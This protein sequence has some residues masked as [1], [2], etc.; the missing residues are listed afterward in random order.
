MKY[1][2]STERLYS[3]SSLGN[4]TTFVQLDP[5][6]NIHG[7]W[8]SLN[9]SFYLGKLSV[10]FLLG[11]KGVAPRETVF[12]PSSQST[13]LRA[14]DLEIVKRVA[15]PFFEDIETLPTGPGKV[16]VDIDVKN[17][18]DNAAELLI[19]SDF[20]FPAVASP[21]FT[22]KP[23]AEDSAK[24]FVITYTSGSLTA[25]EVGSGN[26]VVA[27]FSEPA[28]SHAT[29]DE[30][31]ELQ[32]ALIV[33]PHES[34]SFNIALYLG[35][36]KQAD[37]LVELASPMNDESASSA[38]LEELLKT[39]EFLT[40]SG[41]INR[42][43]YWAKVNTLRVQ[44]K[45][46]SG[47]GFT[48]DPPQDIVVVR[49]LAW[50]MMGSDYFRPAFSREL[51]ELTEKYCYHPDGKLTEFI[52]ADENIPELHDYNL[53][54]NDDTPLFI[55]ALRHH[56]HLDRDPD[57]VMR[58][59]KLAVP[60]VDYIL[61]QMKDG[62]IYSTAAGTNVEGIASWRNIIDDYNLSGFVT[63]INAECCEAL[64][65]ASELAEMVG[66]SKLSERYEREAA[67]LEQNILSK[68]RDGE[69]GFFLLNIDQKGVPHRDVTGDLV[70]PV[71]FE[72]GD[73]K[74][75]LKIV[76]RL[77]SEDLWTKHGARTVAASDPTYDPE[78]GMNLMGGIW[79]NLTAWFA[80]ASKEFYSDV[81][82]EAMEKIYSISESAS[83]R[84][85]G[86]VIP[87]EFPERLHGE[88]FMSMGMGMSP[89]MPPTYLW[90]GI[91]G[92]LGLKVEKGSVK[93]EPSMPQAWSFLCV[94]DIPI[95]SEKLSV[96]IYNGI[97]YSDLEIESEL[98]SRLGVFTHICRNDGLRVFKFTDN[99]GVKFFAFSF[100]EYTGSV[101]IPVNEHSIDFNLSLGKD[102]MQEIN[103]DQ[104]D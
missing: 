36:E 64:R 82:A 100:D 32:F 42:G 96:V 1:V 11:G 35:R 45:F 58:A 27:R 59:F 55:L 89:W 26:N 3:G 83:P 19:K 94:F 39:S 66:A 2:Y 30:T 75:R 24:K 73:R 4:L 23:P 88:T 52:H 5:E 76:N 29:D 21:L 79:P 97:L 62:L 31:A 46:R 74:V 101:T 16:F 99:I 48:N 54:I 70:F 51:V 22:K 81:V 7:V 103:V 37:S 67:R 20:I 84:D 102:E 47:F 71:L 65:A 17:D 38:K 91:E 25:L 34:R 41:T 61:S 60:A 40:P 86:N 95:A 14:G 87:G 49:D 28:I 78:F 77:L 98:P 6:T 92:L 50:Y 53:N 80:L 12:E 15:L 90:L 63:E 72:I 56:V 104:A 9:N 33:S 18:S 44:H 10:N 69:N 85:F 8:S 68:L 43:I 57:F 13:S 93:I